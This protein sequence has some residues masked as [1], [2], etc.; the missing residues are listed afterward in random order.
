MLLFQFYKGANWSTERL[1]IWLK[2]TQT[3]HFGVRILTQAREWGLN[4]ASRTFSCS[5]HDGGDAFPL[6]SLYTL[7]VT[8]KWPLA[9]STLY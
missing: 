3:L 7:C 6:A 5:D 9:L 8:V 4:P 1:G 2:V